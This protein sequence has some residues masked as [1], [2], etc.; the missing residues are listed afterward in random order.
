M[1]ASQLDE[2]RALTAS[3]E[4]AAAEHAQL[5]TAATRQ[6]AGDIQTT[7]AAINEMGEKAATQ[8]G[9]VHEGFGRAGACLDASYSSADS[10]ACSEVQLFVAGVV[11]IGEL[12][13]S[14]SY[15]FHLIR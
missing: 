11:I 7:R 15:D 10:P 13:A 12:R 3:L 9:R 5:R 2:R 8:Y 14:R 4:A 6:K 1:D